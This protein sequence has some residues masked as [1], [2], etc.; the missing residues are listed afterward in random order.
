MKARERSMNARSSRSG[1]RAGVRQPPRRAIARTY[2]RILGTN[3]GSSAL[4]IAALALVGEGTTAT[5]LEGRF[6][7]DGAR[8]EPDVAG[9]LLRDLASLGLVRVARGTSCP[10]YVTTSLGHNLLEHGM[11]GDA[12]EPLRDLERLRTELL[13]TIAHELR[14]P[15]TVVRTSTGLL[16][17]PASSPTEEQRR[18][19][20]E[21]IER[22]AERMQRLIGDVLD[23]ARFRAG[24]IA[25]QLR[26]F[27]PRE[28]TESVVATI[29]AL[30][31]RRG[32]SLLLDAPPDPLPRLFADRPRLERA[33]LN[34]LSNA[35]R[36]TP[37]AGVIRVVVRV[38][39][40]RIA[41]DVIDE[42]PGISEEDQPHLFERFFVGRNDRNESHEGVG[43][44]LP[45][46]LAIAQAHGG[47]IDVRSRPGHGS[48]F[49]LVVP[50]AG[51]PEEV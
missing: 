39:G 7:A 26:Q 32:Q 19:M 15:L 20:L 2:A 30:A 45:T 28:L 33:L 14:T 25:L 43:L 44:G 9:R 31:A 6:A 4:T 42:G 12:S 1:R 23:L 8:L 48:T 24:K 17:D 40:G 47:T 37:D 13:A 10:R 50:L 41:W 35:Q 36:F 49:T 34:L 51:P 11:L 3:V 16:L 27:D 22:N 29:C 5:E 21:N 18:A 38:G 46:S